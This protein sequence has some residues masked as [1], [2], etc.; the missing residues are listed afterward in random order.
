[1]SSTKTV[2]ITGCS[3]GKQLIFYQFAKKKKKIIVPAKNLLKCN[4][5]NF[6]EF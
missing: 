6:T 3:R 5:I 4:K 2:L 1:M